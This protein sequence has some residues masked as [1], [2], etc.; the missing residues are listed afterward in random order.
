MPR[1]NF[2]LLLQKESVPVLTTQAV[3]GKAKLSKFVNELALRYG[4]VS[5]TT[6]RI[7]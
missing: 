4:C 2:V 1:K 5:S 7:Q 6:A 3:S